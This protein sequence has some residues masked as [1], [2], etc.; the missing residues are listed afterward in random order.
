MFCGASNFD[1]P[2]GE[3]NV[4]KVTRMT[5]MVYNAS[6]FNQFLGGWNVSNV[7]MLFASPYDE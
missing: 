2:I 6:N 5:G 4:S 7:D 3:W 1:Q